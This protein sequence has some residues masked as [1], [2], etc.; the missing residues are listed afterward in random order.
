MN[1]CV[2]IFILFLFFFFN[3]FF[4]LKYGWTALYTAAVKGFE[5]IVKFLVEHGSNVDL[6][7]KVFI[8][9]FFLISFFFVFSH[10]FIC[11]CGFIVGSFHVDCEWVCCDIYLVFILF[12]TM[13]K[14]EQAA[15]HTAADN[16]FEQIVKILIEHG[17]NVDLQNL[18][19]IFFF[20]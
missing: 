5:Q 20:F 16:G 19:L 18:V 11:C 15:L 9:F 12:L 7:T 6:Q 14:D 10:F 3:N 1:G 13:L 2:V 17:S 4:L 8:F